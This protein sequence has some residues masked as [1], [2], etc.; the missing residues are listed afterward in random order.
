MRRR[1][2]AIAV[3]DLVQMLDQEIAPPRLIGEQRAHFGERLRIDDAALRNR[4]NPG[5]HAKTRIIGQ[6]SAT[7]S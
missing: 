3:V 1:E 7:L 2:M 4:A 6:P 5:L